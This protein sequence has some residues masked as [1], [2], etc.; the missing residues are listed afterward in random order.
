LKRPCAL[1]A[2][3]LVGA[4]GIAL[5]LMN[6]L[7]DRADEKLE[8]VNPFGN[9]PAPRPA[10][11]PTEVGGGEKPEGPDTSSMTKAELYEK[12]TEL[13]VKGRSKMT[14]AELAEAIEKAS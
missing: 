3:A 7:A 6:Y 10:P 1:G 5:A 4:I 12:A 11:E 13:G 2:A 8:A 14:K 9:E